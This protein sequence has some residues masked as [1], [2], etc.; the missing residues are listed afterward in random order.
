MSVSDT[1]PLM[2]HDPALVPGM[3][4]KTAAAQMLFWA[5][6]LMS[7]HSAAH[8][9]S[10]STSGIVAIG[11]L[12]T[13]AV[14]QSTVY[15]YCRSPTIWR[16]FSRSLVGQENGI[17]MTTG[18][19]SADAVSVGRA[20]PDGTSDLC[21]PGVIVGL[22]SL[23]TKSKIE[24]ALLKRVDKVEAVLASSDL[25]AVKAFEESVL[26]RAVSTDNVV[27]VVYD[28]VV[29]KVTKTILFIPK[30]VS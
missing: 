3:G 20:D 10:F 22:D 28:F 25:E 9:N 6:L 16:W 24:L 30:I 23:E 19:D 8:A 1:G 15:L 4:V 14:L 17:P 5:L 27:V 21:G 7:E 2:R 26:P 12:A 18:R 11:L 29:V 13:M